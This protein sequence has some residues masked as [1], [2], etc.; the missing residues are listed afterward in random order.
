MVISKRNVPN[1][2]WPTVRGL[3]G[4]KSYFTAADSN[5]L[6]YNG[7]VNCPCFQRPIK[8]SKTALE[9]ML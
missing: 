1:V 3:A 6:T 8:Q 4:N 9:M 2:A 5:R 7:R